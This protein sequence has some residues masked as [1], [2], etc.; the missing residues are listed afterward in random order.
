VASLLIG[1]PL[2]NLFASWLVALGQG[3]RA[4]GNVAEYVKRQ[5]S[6]LG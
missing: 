6:G 5:E 2:A 4:L 1:G 3:P